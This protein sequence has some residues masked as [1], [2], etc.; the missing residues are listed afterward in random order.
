[1]INVSRSMASL[2]K[3]SKLIYM[4]FTLFFFGWICRAHCFLWWRHLHTYSWVAHLG[5]LHFVQGQYSCS[6]PNTQGHLDNQ[7][8]NLAWPQLV[9]LWSVAKIHWESVD[10]SWCW[11]NSIQT[12]REEGQETF[13]SVRGFRANTGDVRVRRLPPSIGKP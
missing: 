2:T 7:H 13:I 10:D 12:H 3:G 6:H 8:L 11:Y 9:V 4:K 5:I 1:M